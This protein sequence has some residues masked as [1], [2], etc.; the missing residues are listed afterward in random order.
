MFRARIR[1]E[2]KFFLDQHFGGERESYFSLAKG[3][4][5]CN[6][7]VVPFKYM[8]LPVGVNPHRVATQEPLVGLLQSRICSWR[9]KFITFGGRIV[10]LNLV[11]YSIPILSSLILRCM[12]GCGGNWFD[13]RGISY[14]VFAWIERKFL[15][16][17]GLNCASRSAGVVLGSRI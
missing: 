1:V 3:F 12:W 5:H 15:G 7:G 9:N 13:C 17:A 11:L 10:L 4:L 8:G 14:G 2:G 16:C 6:I